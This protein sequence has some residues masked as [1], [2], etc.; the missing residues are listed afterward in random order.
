L[1]SA[2]PGDLDG[3]GWTDFVATDGDLPQAIY[4][5]VNLHDGGFG[6]TEIDPSL[7]LYL[8]QTRIADFDSDGRPDLVTCT[9]QGLFV[10]FDDGGAPSYRTPVPI[11]AAD[12]AN[13]AVGDLNGDGIPDIV[14]VESGLVV[15]LG[16][17]DGG[18]S[19]TVMPSSCNPDAAG[20]LAAVDLNGD[21]QA[22]V[23]CGSSSG[24]T[25]RF[26]FD[27]GQLG[28]EVSYDSG[29]PYQQVVV[30]DFNGDGL[31]DVAVTG[32]D[33]TSC[34]GIDGGAAV[35]FNIGDGGFGPVESLASG[36][37]SFGISPLRASGAPL[38]GLAVGDYCDA[39]LSIFSNVVG[40]AGS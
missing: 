29:G 26:S 37:P 22:D 10:F 30:A 12:C 28:S 39:N 11:D 17:G 15:H 9:E 25:L 31:P 3:D 32:S 8:Y 5:A 4:I 18:F 6:V 40:D 23:I 7:G 35:F 16:D 34:S 2:V 1:I 14:A 24:I 36:T 21:G 33:P 20:R 38:P 27:G 19:T 13:L